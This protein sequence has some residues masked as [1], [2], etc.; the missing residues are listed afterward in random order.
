MMV[1]EPAGRISSINETPISA[2]KCVILSDGL[3][4]KIDNTTNA[5]R[6]L[7]AAD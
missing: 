4:D 7:Q 1:G 3:I 6:A 5:L 2:N